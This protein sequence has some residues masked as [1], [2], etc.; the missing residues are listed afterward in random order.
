MEAKSSWLCLA[1]MMMT[2]SRVCVQHNHAIEALRRARGLPS[3]DREGARKREDVGLG[4]RATPDAR[5]MQTYIRGWT[6]IKWPGMGGH[7]ATNTFSPAGTNLSCAHPRHDTTLSLCRTVVDKLPAAPE[8]A[9]HGTIAGPCSAV[10]YMLCDSTGQPHDT[11]VPHATVLHAPATRPSRA[12]RVRALHVHSRPRAA[13]LARR[14]DYPD[15]ERRRCRID[16][17]QRRVV[18]IDGAS[19]A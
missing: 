2:P 16:A 3:G 18:R 4:S 6:N 11:L 8:G 14:L 12:R 5:R 7:Q 17:E 1:A 10:A 19:E 15:D 9:A 13:A